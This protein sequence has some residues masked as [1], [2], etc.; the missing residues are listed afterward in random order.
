[1]RIVYF[2]TPEFSA[3]FLQH[4]ADHSPDQLVAVVT[5]PDR[6]AGRG[7]HLRSSP[8]KL[9]A[10]KLQLPVF[11]PE[12]LR[13]ESFLEE[14]RRLSP[15][16]FVVIAF[17]ILPAELLEIPRLGSINLHG[18]LLP[19][20]R[21][22]A[23]VQWAVVNGESESGLTI[24]QLDSKMDHGPVIEKVRLPIGENETAS[25]LFERLVEAGRPALLSALR[26]V[27]EGYQPLEQEHQLATRAPKLRKEDGRI[28][29]NWSAEK[30]HNLI[31][32]MQPWPAAWGFFEGKKIRFWESRRS[33]LEREAP[34]GRLLW[35]ESVDALCIK[36]GDGWIEIVKLQPEGKRVMEGGEFWCGLQ[37]RQE[38]VVE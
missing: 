11:Q 2:G 24:F 1:M 35:D 23:P 21:G 12:S 34:V 27:E 14:L 28:D 25:E 7:L 18:S 31:R 30:I 29:W 15:D 37:Q 20:Y 26:K 6:P 38:L 8:V 32:G 19:R 4:I 17:S 13:D 22:A 16:L 9:V 5:Q 36:T 10:E 3:S 33:N